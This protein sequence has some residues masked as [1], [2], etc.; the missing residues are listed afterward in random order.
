MNSETCKE[1]LVSHEYIGSY[2][3]FYNLLF[4]VSNQQLKMANAE[5]VSIHISV[6]YDVCQGLLHI[7]FITRCT[8]CM[9]CFFTTI[10]R[11]YQHFYRLRCYE[12][13]I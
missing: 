2:C 10:S 7:Y 9:D 11:V 8:Q 13:N 12:I 3:D 4:K 5:T 1:F 6:L